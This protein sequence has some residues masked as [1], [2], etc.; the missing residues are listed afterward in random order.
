MRNVGLLLTAAAAVLITGFSAVPARAHEDDWYG[1]RRHEWQEHEWRERAW[2]R[3]EWREH[4]WRRHQWGEHHR[5]YPGDY[6]DSG[7]YA[8]PDY[9]AY[10]RVP[11]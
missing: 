6:N 3:H 11:Q 4:A 5:Y 10:Y 8:R 1:W 7:Y 2:R 9:R